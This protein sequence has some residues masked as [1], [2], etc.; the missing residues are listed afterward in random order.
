[1]IKIVKIK[2]REWHPNFGYTKAVYGII[3]RPEIRI[4]KDFLSWRCYG[5]G[6]GLMAD[7][8]KELENQLAKILEI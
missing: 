8:R 7:N 6:V 5:I 2:P 1:M 4:V 3:D